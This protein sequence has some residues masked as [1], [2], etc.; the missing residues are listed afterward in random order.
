M[1]DFWCL[2]SISYSVGRNYSIGILVMLLC[3]FKSARQ[4]TLLNVMFKH[5]QQN[6][7]NKNNINNYN[8]LDKFDTQ[9]D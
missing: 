3:L 6:N 4:L 1:A 7:N 8:N 2:R 9:F 5:G